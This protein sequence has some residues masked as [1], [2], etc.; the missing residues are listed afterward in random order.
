M[1]R[2]E[3]E[4]GPVLI[5][6]R[7][8]EEITNFS[9]CVHGMLLKLFKE[10]CMNIYY[11][12]VDYTIRKGKEKTPSFPYPAVTLSLINKGIRGPGHDGSGSLR[13]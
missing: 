3:K 1:S 8:G 13:K 2:P 9:F 10:I 12:E 6:L 4:G 7:S 5:M 11:S